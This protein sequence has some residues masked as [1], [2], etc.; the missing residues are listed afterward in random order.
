MS[1]DWGNA[2]GFLTLAPPASGPEVWPAEPQSG[3]E[4]VRFR[5][6]AID[7]ATGR[8]ARG[9][10]AVLDGRPIADDVPGLPRPDVAAALGSPAAA[11]SGFDLT[12]QVP[13]GAGR[14]VRVLAEAADGA[15]RPLDAAPGIEFEGDAGPDGAAAGYLDLRRV[16]VHDGVL[17]LAPLS[18]DVAARARLRLVVSGGEPGRRYRLGE[19]PPWASEPVAGAVID[20][21][22]PRGGRVALPVGACPQWWGYRDRPLFLWS[23]DGRPVPGLSVAWEVAP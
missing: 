13:R 17:R 11:G 12:V 3:P 9:V 14:R 2:G 21:A 20:F 6:W 19:F 18:L 4:T 22:S 8:P 15:L 16:A 7:R 23:E 5:W 10:V 1:C